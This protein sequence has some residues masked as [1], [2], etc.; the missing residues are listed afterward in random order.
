MPA[1][2][3][4]IVLALAVVLVAGALPA[5]AG[6][7]EWSRLARLE[8]TSGPEP[9]VSALAAHP[10]N[11]AILY[12]GVWLTTDDAALVYRSGDGGQTWLPAASGLPDDL[13]EN[14]G[15]ED[16]ALLPGNPPA[17][18]AAVHQRGVWRSDDGGTTWES[19][20]GGS[21]GADED[22]AA[23]VFAPGA[24]A[25]VYALSTDGVSLLAEGKPWQTRATGLPEPGTAVFHD[26]AIDPT[27]PDVLYVATSPAGLFRSRNGGKTWVDSNGDLPGGVRNVKGVAVDAN[28]TVFLTLRGAGLY[29]STDGG[30]S[31]NSTQEGITFQTTLF[32]TVSAPVF[33]PAEPN[34]AFAYNNDGVFRTADGGA[35]W[36]PYSLGLSPTA[37]ISTLAFHTARP[38]TTLGG[39]SISG[40]WTVTDAPSGRF[41]VP[42]IRR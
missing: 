33:D 19:A 30:E 3:I 29:R 10:T 20:G 5:A 32:G 31:W 14:T 2:R 40:V 39:T 12:A 41:F 7:Y 42:V 11:P 35:T 27:N 34:V 8:G 15:I 13:P 4:Y 28:G 18:Y 16:L 36:T 6:L 1:K 23:L 25:G 22:V 17:L 38:H 37:F 24:A 26:L 9:A 21:L